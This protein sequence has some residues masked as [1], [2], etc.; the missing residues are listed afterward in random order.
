MKI[1]IFSMQCF[2]KIVTYRKKKGEVF[3]QQLN[4]QN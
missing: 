2:D 4:P 3:S 1:A